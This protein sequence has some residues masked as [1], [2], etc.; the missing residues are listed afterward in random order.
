[1]FE[2]E[3]LHVCLAGALLPQCKVLQG[4]V[5]NS[6]TKYDSDIE[7]CC[8]DFTFAMIVPFMLWKETFSS[9]FNNTLKMI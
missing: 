1:M 2:Q 5:N 9:F 6:G 7:E 4:V 8:V 3:C